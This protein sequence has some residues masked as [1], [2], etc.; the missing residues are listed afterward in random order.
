M[1]AAVTGAGAAES[2]AA[3]GGEV[4]RGFQQH[5]GGDLGENSG[6]RGKKAKK[7]A[8]QRCARELAFLIT[9]TLG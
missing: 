5:P 6:R 7:K 1:A 2:S 9:W 8:R 3:G 4:L